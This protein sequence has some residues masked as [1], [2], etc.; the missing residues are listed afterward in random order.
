MKFSL[1]NDPIDSVALLQSVADDRAGACVSF[2]GRVRNHH[3]GKLVSALEYE[4]ADILAISEGR[5][6]LTEAIERFS[7]Y[8][9]AAAHRLGKLSIGEV[10]VVV[11]VT[12]AHRKE[13]FLACEWVIDEIKSRVPIWKKEYYHDEAPQWVLC[14]R[15]GEAHSHHHDSA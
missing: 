2:E 8:H 9:A 15:C 1:S 3:Q 4:A 10:A 11:H 14:S 12:S 7:L 6:I 5:K 13:A